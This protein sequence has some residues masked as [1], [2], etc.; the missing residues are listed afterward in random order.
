M[1]TTVFVLCCFI[2]LPCLAQA[3]TIPMPYDSADWVSGS[4]QD[5]LFIGA[6]EVL[7]DI[8]LKYQFYSGQLFPNDPGGFDTVQPTFADGIGQQ[9]QF[10]LTIGRWKEHLKQ[11]LDTYLSQDPPGKYSDRAQQ[12]RSAITEEF[13]P[14][15]LGPDEA[16]A[17]TA[18]NLVTFY[19]EWIVQ[20]AGITGDDAK[21]RIRLTTLLRWAREDGFITA[22]E[23][24]AY[25]HDLP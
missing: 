9:Y 12:L 10:A 24:Q 15:F 20:E 25:L 6:F 5:R 23:E 8:L 21:D 3:Q 13:C 19:R 16:T 4:D 7:D 22:A 14:L 18:E 1:K 17:T 2:V 11:D